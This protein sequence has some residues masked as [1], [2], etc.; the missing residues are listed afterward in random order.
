MKF[1]SYKEHKEKKHEIND[2]IL[3]DP[4]E[5]VSY[6]NGIIY[7]YGVICLSDVKVF[8]LDPENMPTYKDN[9]Y[10]WD[11]PINVK[12]H[13]KLHFTYDGSVIWQLN[14]PKPKIMED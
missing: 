14:L 13:L 8:I 5:F 2:Y 7:E 10:Y 4:N 11:K 12:N 6:F 1:R 9:K 3:D